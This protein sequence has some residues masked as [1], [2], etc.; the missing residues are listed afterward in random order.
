MAIEDTKEF[1]GDFLEHF[2]VKGMRWGHRSSS[3]SSGHGPKPKSSEDAKEAAHL[4]AK[5]KKDGTK[6]LSNKELRA[7]VDRMSLEKRFKEINTPAAK[8][9]N[10][11]LAGA[12]WTTRKMATIT[13]QSVEQVIK[14]NLANEMNQRLKAQI[15][16][17][18]TAA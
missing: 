14:A 3:S 9:Q 1:V 10:P 17:N 2:G 5:V 7:L 12:A 6:A 8:K 15:N 4:S 16:S 13:G 11:I 18:K